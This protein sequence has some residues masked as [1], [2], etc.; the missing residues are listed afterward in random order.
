MLLLATGVWAQSGMSI[1][2]D[3]APPNEFAKF[4]VVAKNKGILIPRMSSAERDSIHPTADAEALLVYDTTYKAF[5]YYNS[6]FWE[7]VTTVE[8]LY[9]QIQLVIDD[10]QISIS[11]INPQTI[12]T[13]TL[14]EIQQLTISRDTI[15]LSEG[16]F[17]KL[18][19]SNDNDAD[20]TNEL[21]TLSI[22]GNTI[23]LSS[24]G[25]V[26][27]PAQQDNDSDPT[28]EFQTLSIDGNVISL[29]NGGTV[30]LPVQN[31]ND[32]D[33]T[34][35]IQD[36]YLSNDTLYITNNDDP[37][38]IALAAY[39]GTNTWELER[40][41][42]YTITN[43]QTSGEAQVHWNNLTNV[44]T[45]TDSINWNIAYSWG[46]HATAGYLASESDPVFT[47][48]DRSTGI[49]ISESQILDL[50]HFSGDYSD[51]SNTP[52]FADSI[53]WSTAYSWGN[54][55][56]AGYLTTE[57]D[58]VFGA[59]DR[60][61]GISITESQ[62]S[63]LSHFSG[64]Y[65]DLTNTPNLA[66]S[67]NWNT[68]FNWGD[69]STIGYL[70]TET[71]PVFDAWDRSTGITITESQISDLNH[72]SG[73]Y[74]D[75]TNT[76]DLADSTN[77]NTAFGWGDHSTAGYL[78]TETDPEYNAAIT[79]LQADTIPKWNGAAFV[80]SQIADDGTV[81]TIGTTPSASDYKLIVNGRFKSAGVNEISDR[82]MKKNIR[83]IED[84]ALEKVTQMQGVKYE[85]RKEK[86]PSL[87]LPDSTEIGFIAQEVEKYF[88]E[89]VMTDEAGYKTV[90][91]TRVVA[92]LLE[93]VKEL[94]CIVIKQQSSINNL[95]AEN[96]KLQEMSAS[97]ETLQKQVELLNS[98]ML[99]SKLSDGK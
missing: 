64:D 74:T 45:M 56:T 72:F 77:W 41:S 10:S 73:D 54:H 11:G 52:D 36:L 4:E 18:P 5:F 20:P 39:T 12:D 53:N 89:L 28:N 76:P 88:P 99:T 98:L 71:D 22:T 92:V 31:D 95:T 2:K 87:N 47:N 34:N 27:L 32:A 58:P 40:N 83:P 97:I 66:D 43:L 24:G 42:Y 33:S 61:S 37:T 62:I 84:G 75:L 94:N 85:W 13:D 69:H 17:V 51:L 44:P 14:N 70:T 38:G 59:W 57:T 79:G 21:Q 82:R 80:N 26:D 49:T 7:Q 46:N 50:S 25:Q 8:R 68:A 91:Y 67:L 93:A 23:F 29:S 1:G 63:D 90:Q 60:S 15:Y 48:W 81:V 16:G 96:E 6:M 19:V 86:Y 78:S 55:A 65:T 3:G 9:Q 30:T 35:E